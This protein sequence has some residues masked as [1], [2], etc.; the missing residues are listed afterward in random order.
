MG[1]ILPR[2]ATRPNNRL[3]KMV[4][5]R[6]RLSQKAQETRKHKCRLQIREEIVME[7][8]VPHQDHKA[9]KRAASISFAK[10]IRTS[11]QVPPHNRSQLVSKEA[12]EHT[13]KQN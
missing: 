8:A 9:N 11:P 5:K 1:S 3:K 10:E 6:H 2:L 4:L 12:T 13:S 7:M